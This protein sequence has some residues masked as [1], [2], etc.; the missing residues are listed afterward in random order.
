M[1]KSSVAAIDW[2]TVLL[3]LLLVGFGWGNIYSASYENEAISLTDLSIVYVKQ[4]YWILFSIVIIIIIQAIEAKFY[5]RFAGLIY[6]IALLSLLGLFVFGKTISGATSWYA[7][8]R[9]AY[10]PQNLQRQPLLSL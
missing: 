4:G 2:I 6:V 10:N 1:A 5:E 7:F 8:V 3:F 9:L